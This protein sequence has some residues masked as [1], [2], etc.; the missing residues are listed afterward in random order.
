MSERKIIT[1]PKAMPLGKRISGVS[2]E[3]ST[4]LASLEIPYDAGK[5]VV[6]LTSCEKEDEYRYHY[7]LDRSVKGPDDEKAG[8]KTPVNAKG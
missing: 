6:H 2:R 4:W 5:D 7:T 1:L 3:I 8:R